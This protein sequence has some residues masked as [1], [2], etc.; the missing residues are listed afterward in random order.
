MGWRRNSREEHDRVGGGQ[1]GEDD[2]VHVHVVVLVVPELADKLDIAKYMQRKTFF[3]G[4]QE[5]PKVS[6]F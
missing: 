6:R 1:R 5:K 3:F 2:G 4:P